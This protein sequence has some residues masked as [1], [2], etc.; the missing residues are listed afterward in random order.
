MQAS[1]D[2]LGIDAAVRELPGSARTAPEA[3]AAVGV[4][5]GQIVKSLVFRAGEDAVLILVSG[6]NRADEALVAA[7]LGAAVARMDADEVR[8]ATGYAIGGVPPLGHPCALRTLVDADLLAYDVLWAAGGTPRC[9][10][11]IEPGALVRA[12]GGRVVSVASA[13]AR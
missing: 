4:Q 7:E 12:T 2:A 3:A 11:P 8:A 5:V 13:P 9:V 6:A 1:L 10:F